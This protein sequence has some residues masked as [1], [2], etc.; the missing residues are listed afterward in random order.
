MNRAAEPTL[1]LLAQ[2]AGLTDCA[3]SEGFACVCARRAHGAQSVDVLQPQL[4]IVLQGS[5][6]VRCEGGALVVHPGE[7]MVVTRACRIDVVNVP[8]PHSGLYQTVLVPLCAEVLAAARS[9]WQ[10]ALP[11]P[12]DAVVGVPL[13]PLGEALS[14]WQRALTEARYAEARLALAA[15]TLDLCRRG[16]GALLLPPPPSFASELRTLVAAQPAREWQSRDFE[17]A[18]GVSGATL[19]RRL[20]EAGTGLRE[21]VADARLAHAMELLYTTRLPLKTVAAR[22]GYRSLGSF[23][24]RFHARY[25]LDPADIGNALRTA[26]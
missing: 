2:L 20:A 15:V 23:S 9:L 26:A 8:D 24:R 16:H 11:A 17:Q 10:E 13:A 19:R 12:G 7:V 14:R 3:R 21:V 5:K 4:A 18:F 1:F 25:Q 22:V 6:Q